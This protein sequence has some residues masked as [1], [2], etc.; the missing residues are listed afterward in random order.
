MTTRPWRARGTDRLAIAIRIAASLAALFLLVLATGCG[1]ARSTPEEQLRAW[2]AA[3]E[4][5]AEGKAR[6][7]I[8]ELIAA[9]YND[10]RGNARDDVDKLLRF[11]FLR[12]HTIALLTAVD[13][14]EVAGGNS[15]TMTVTVAMAGTDDR[16]SGLSGLSADAYRFELELEADGD[17]E[18]YSD[19][20]LLSARWGALG[21]PVR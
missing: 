13:E 10:S 17:P 18:S 4:S 7:S 3:V 2:I 1:G 11:Y 8:M 9:A 21:E 5:A 6:T 15:A 19:W 14:I 12:Q 20:R 16:G